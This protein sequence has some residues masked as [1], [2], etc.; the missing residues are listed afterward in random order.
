[1]TSVV[2]AT[3]PGALEAHAGV[4]RTDSAIREGGCTYADA[5]LKAGISKSTFQL[6]KQRG[7]EQK[8][9]QYPDF[10]DHLE[11]AEADFRAHYLKKIQEAAKGDSR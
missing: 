11:K 8:R 7:Q 9:G 6:W 1:M 3:K 2:K 5:C 10:S 4:P